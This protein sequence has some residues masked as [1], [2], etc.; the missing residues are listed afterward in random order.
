MGSLAAGGA[1]AMG[2]GA[3]T[4]MSAERDADIDVVTDENGLLALVAGEEPDRVYQ[5]SD[6]E[7]DIT[8]T[9]D[10]G[11]EGVNVNSRYQVGSMRGPGPTPELSSAGQPQNKGSPEEN[12]AFSV[13]NQDS[14]SHEVT[15]EYEADDPGDSVVWFQA[16]PSTGPGSP[17]GQADL[18]VTSG[19]NPN[20]VTRE[21]SPGEYLGVSILVD[22][23]DGSV[24]DDLT[25]TLTVSGN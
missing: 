2:S 16:V 5:N 10:Q 21:I 19:K 15:L 18:E 13:V 12:T 25:G 24:D 1:A 4:A 14:V 11:G 8:F 20:S 22:T 7:L 6:G 9:S 17:N 3:F 23:R